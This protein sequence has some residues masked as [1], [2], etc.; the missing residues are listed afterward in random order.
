MNVFA[1]LQ[2]QGR[3]VVPA[4]YASEAD[5]LTPGALPVSCVVIAG[6][7][8]E[9]ASDP[10]YLPDASG[11]SHGSI[12]GCPTPRTD[13]WTGNYTQS[14]V[15]RL[16]RIVDG[17]RRATGSDRVDLACLS[18]GNIVGRAYARWHSSGARGGV[19]KVRS[20]FFIAGPQRGLDA[21]E[22]Y[23]TGWL[24]TPDTE[25][26]RQGEVAEMCQEYAVWSGR[27]FVDEL[28][29][30][31]DT[32]C[33]Q[34]D[35]SYAGLS[36]TGAHGKQVDPQGS[37][38]VNDIIIAIGN[39]VSAI[40]NPPTIAD[41]KP[42]LDIFRPKLFAEVG[43]ALGPSD[44][45]VRLALSRLDGPPFG[46]TYL[47]APLEVRHQREWNP[48][49]SATG[50]TVTSELAR[51]FFD[52]RLGP[53]A[54]IATFDAVLVDAPGKASWIALESTVT[55]DTMGAQLVEETLDAKGNPVGGAVGYGCRV[56]FGT[57]RV[58]FQVPA[59]GGDRRYHAV[60]YSAQGSIATRDVALHLTAGAQDSPPVTT[61]AGATSQPVGG[62]PA[63]QA[64]FAS[65]AGPQDTTLG[66]SY[67]LDE[68]PWSSF[69]Q[70]PSLT[71]PPLGPG[72]HRL[73]ARA[74]HS[75]NG[76]GLLC[77]D[78][79]GVTVGLFVDASGALTVR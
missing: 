72:E 44:G 67:R 36:G 74:Q 77:Q 27:S 76:A 31:W 30:G 6:Y 73:E 47:W 56:L 78:M 71:T 33:A 8:R 28:N 15:E 10:K 25:F 52:R 5:Q 64:T 4:L 1:A 62:W 54:Q 45:V 19:S 21:L 23:A 61:F 11:V 59:T 60:L 40:L 48:E 14:Y 34:N 35:V 46:R 49:Q 17:V 20:M 63:V 43:E 37:A 53:V 3:A 65:N 41:L 12:G 26:M 13:P 18:M 7:Y 55:A 16:G 51:T 50:S 79:H 9:H 29:D 39:V 42:Y 24:R 38:I 2:G 68:G 57:Q 58:F 69:T 22:A 70:S 75:T 66:F 32:F